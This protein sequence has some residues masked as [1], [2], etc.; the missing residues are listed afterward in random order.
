MPQSSEYEARVTST[1]PQNLMDNSPNINELLYHWAICLYGNAYLSQSMTKELGFDSWY[2]LTFI[3]SPVTRPA[4]GFQFQHEADHSPPT[5]RHTGIN[6]MFVYLPHSIRV[7]I[8]DS[9]QDG[10]ANLREV[11]HIWC[12]GCHFIEWVTAINMICTKLC[13]QLQTRWCQ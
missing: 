12:V 1:V 2:G 6:F 7:H 8:S 9:C 13:N 11:C 3:S 10:T 4:L 5:S